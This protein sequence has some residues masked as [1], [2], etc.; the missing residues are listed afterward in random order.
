MKIEDVSRGRKLVG[1]EERGGY[2][3]RCEG[4]GGSKNCSSCFVRGLELFWL[5]G[6]IV[7]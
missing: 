1:K 7:S 4:F 6:S 5:I 3:G 2:V